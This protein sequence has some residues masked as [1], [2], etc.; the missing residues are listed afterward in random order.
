MSEVSPI[1]KKRTARNLNYVFILLYCMLAK[2]PFYARVLLNINT[3]ANKFI[4][5]CHR[6]NMSVLK[7]KKK[8][9]LDE[10]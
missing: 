10:K 6:K 7:I 8:H 5:Y 4:Y 3:K 2:Y 9:Y 1:D